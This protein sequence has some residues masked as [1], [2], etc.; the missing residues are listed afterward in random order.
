MVEMWHLQLL[1]TSRGFF[2]VPGTEV[3][4]EQKNNFLDEILDWPV[5]SADAPDVVQPNQSVLHR[6]Q[7]V[8]LAQR[9]LGLTRLHVAFVAAEQ[10]SSLSHLTR[11]KNI[12]HFGGHHRN[13]LC[14]SFKISHQLICVG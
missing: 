6:Q 1:K 9:R 7:R 8:G 4:F 5:A 2:D 12:N 11:E 10:R 13:A 14:D 3:L